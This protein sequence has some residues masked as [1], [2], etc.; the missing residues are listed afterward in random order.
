MSYSRFVAPVLAALPP[1][2]F[3]AVVTGDT[4]HRGK[5]HP[6]PYLVAARELD[7]LAGSC[8]A[9]EDSETGATSAAAAGCTVLWAPLHVS[10]RPG[11]DGSSSSRSRDSPPTPSSRQPTRRNRCRIAT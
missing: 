5:P 2:T 1:D 3:A 11:P 10:V 4:V 6:E 8:L 9:I 7:V